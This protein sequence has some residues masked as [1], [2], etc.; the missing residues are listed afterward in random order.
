MGP[1]RKIAFQDLPKIELH[2][3]LDTSL[4]YQ[5]IRAL[6]PGLT[7]AEYNQEYVAPAQCRDLTDFLRYPASAIALLQTRENLFAAVGQLVREMA[8]DGVIYTEIRFAPLLHIDQGLQ[9]QEVVETVCQAAREA[10]AESGVVT[11]LILCTLRHF[12]ATQSLETADL[13]IAFRDQ[14][15]VGLD[16]AADEAYSLKAHIPAFRKVTEAGMCCTAH[17]GEARG[18]E[19][20]RETLEFLGVRRIGHGVRSVEDEE[21][22]SQLVRQGIHLE[23]CPSSNLQTGV[24][25][26]IR[27]HSIDQLYRHGVSL[28]I[29]TDGRGLTQTTLCRE[30]ELVYQTFGWTLPDFLIVNRMAVQAAYISEELKIDLQHKLEEGYK[31]EQSNG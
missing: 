9:P 22:V 13:V 1:N 2:V 6:R 19:S 14:G 18:P 20:V 25:S 11:R 31:K 17:A 7:I 16:L 8:A 28:S 4:S 29:N 3:H 30:Y 15:V 23:I 5:N 24:F 27:D 12:A 21:L 10:E 26:T